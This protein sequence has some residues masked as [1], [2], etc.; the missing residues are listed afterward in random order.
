MEQPNLNQIEL[1]A[2]N[3]V[4]FKTQLLQ[5]IQKEFPAEKQFY[6]DCV[7]SKDNKKTAEIVHKL[8][9]KISILGLEKGYEIAVH[10]ENALRENQDSFKQDF[11]QVLLSISKFLEMLK[12]EL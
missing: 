1:L 9:H 11:E 7:L 6:E 10:Y 12:K 5:V 2:G 3:D 4:V 8:K